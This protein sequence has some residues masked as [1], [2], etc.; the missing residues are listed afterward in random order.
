MLL[1]GKYSIVICSV[2]AYNQKSWGLF[3]P[4]FKMLVCLSF[5]YEQWC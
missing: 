2:S 4:G 5:P 3:N 1:E